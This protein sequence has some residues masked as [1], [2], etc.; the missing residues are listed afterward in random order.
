MDLPNESPFD[1]NNTEEENYYQILNVPYNATKIQIRE[2]YLKL[3]NAFLPNNNAHYSIM[4]EEELVKQ[5]ELIQEAFL[6]L[7][8]DLQRRLYDKKLGIIQQPTEE[9][10]NKTQSDN[11][12]NNIDARKTETISPFKPKRIVNVKASCA[13][14]PIIQQRLLDLIKEFE[15]LKFDNNTNILKAIRECAQ[16][17]VEEISERTK[18]PIHYIE[19]METY[20]FDKL[21]KQ[22][23]FIRGY[24]ESY[25]KYIGIKNYSKILQIYMNRFNEWINNQKKAY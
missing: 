18:I 11:I 6:T 25:L 21:P 17:S 10:K 1:F 9:N 7:S 19:D 4:S 13:N 2:A 16:I 14:D 24:V 12:L 5:K 23:V 3:K 22:V 20:N 15:E 8:N